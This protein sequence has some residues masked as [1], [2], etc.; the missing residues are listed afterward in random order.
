M[1]QQQLD[2]KTLARIRRDSMRQRARRIRRSVAGLTLALFTAAFV[3]IYVQLAS[4]HDPALSKHQTAAATATKSESESST[5]SGETTS[6]ESSSTGSEESTGSATTGGE[7]SSGE[8]SATGSE[9]TTES[10]SAVTTRQS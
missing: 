5:S 6:S 8:S 1:N 7:E 2:P 10:P 9:E 4:G 3:G